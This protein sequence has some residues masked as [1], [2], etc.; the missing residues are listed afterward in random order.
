MLLTNFF[1]RNFLMFLLQLNI[2]LIIKM[3]N[4]K[5]DENKIIDNKSYIQ[6]NKI[7]VKFSNFL[8]FFFLNVITVIDVTKNIKY[9]NVYT[10]FR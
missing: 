2:T 1:F 7:L 5:L 10:T 3:F 8:Y 4:F 9:R 6:R